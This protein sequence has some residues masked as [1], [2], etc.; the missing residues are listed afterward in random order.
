MVLSGIALN[1]CVF[2]TLLRQPTIQHHGTTE[3]GNKSDCCVACVKIF[4]FSLFRI[5]TF[6][7]YVIAC[8]FN[9]LGYSAN[10]A[11]FPAHMQDIKL[12]EQQLTVAFS[13][14]GALELFSRAFFGWFA[15]LKLIHPKNIVVFCVFL[16]AIFAFVIPMFP[17]YWAMIVY[18]CSIGSFPGAFWS[19]MAVLLLECVELSRLP[20]ALGVLSLFLAVAIMI[21]QVFAGKAFEKV[22]L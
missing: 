16:S 19:L 15:D 5:P 8:F 13:C 1:V 4:D 2:V 11:A 18:G 21:S 22:V 7:L 9:I 10:F 3:K 20:S 12:T 6:R 17:H 14:I